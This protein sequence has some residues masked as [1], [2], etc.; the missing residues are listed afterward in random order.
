MMFVT[1]THALTILVHYNTIYTGQL[2]VISFGPVKYKSAHKSLYSDNKRFFEM[3]LRTNNN[4]IVH[5]ILNNKVSNT[6]QS[7]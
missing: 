3:H 2:Q 1:I 6:V 5:L 7:Y 4:S